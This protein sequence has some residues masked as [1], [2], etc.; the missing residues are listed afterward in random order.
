MLDLMAFAC[1]LKQA[2]DAE[3][4]WRLLARQA[5]LH[6]FDKVTYGFLPLGSTAPVEQAVIWMRNSPAA[7]VEHYQQCDFASHDPIIHHCNRSRRPVDWR[8]L[9]ANCTN[10]RF[11]AE[12]R[13]VCLDARQF[14]LRHGISFPLRDAIGA[15]G[16]ISFGARSD[17]AEQE[18][19][20]DLARHHPL[21]QV[22][23]DM[24]HAGL[25]RRSLAAQRYEL[26]ERERE[27]LKWL[28]VGLKQ[29]NIAHKMGVA[30]PTI[31]LYVRS[32]KRKLNAASTAQI[33]AK[34]VS[35]DLI[36]SC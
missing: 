19:R 27:C 31:E 34:A 30:P 15:K 25:D 13:R 2:P 23:A 32:I 8:E 16:G 20:S 10:G 18:Y 7:W 28:A 29:K 33:I 5:E 12:V 1:A 11:C 9:E 14:G 36:D 4:Q 24:F 17:V 26:N 6:G 3:A 35:L 21:L 22:C